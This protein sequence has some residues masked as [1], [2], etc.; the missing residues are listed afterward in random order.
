MDYRTEQMAA[1]L[2]SVSMRMLRM[3]RRED[4]EAGMS[5]SRLSALSVIVFAGPLSLND[6]SNAEHVRAPT[7]SRIVEHLVQ[8]GLVTREPDPKDR[9][10]I[11]IAATP[12]GRALLDDGR[13]QRVKAI[14]GRLQKLAD[15]ERR[16]LHRGLELME[17][18]TRI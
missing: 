7:M 6:L 16:A 12:A 11:R 10:S 18:L 3:L 9:R 17:R 13:A 2:H 15:S 4:E 8:D 1:Q 5:A 14:G